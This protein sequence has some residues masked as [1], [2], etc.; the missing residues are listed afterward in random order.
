[1]VRA[2]FRLLR[3]IDMGYLD[4]D[5]TDIEVPQN[6]M[7]DIRRNAHER[8]H[9]G[10]L[11]GADHFLDDRRRQRSVLCIKQYEIEADEAGRIDQPGRVEV[12]NHAEARPVC[13]KILAQAMGLDHHIT[14]KNG[15]TAWPRWP[16]FP[17]QSPARGAPPGCKFGPADFSRRNPP[18]LY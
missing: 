15:T 4:A 5:C 17:P 8:A 11:R 13:G 2:C 6:L 9:I 3:R 14:T 7:R 10:G 18:T 12:D 16:L 1:C